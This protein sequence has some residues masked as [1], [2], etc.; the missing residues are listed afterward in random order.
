[1]I[2]A[3]YPQL[4][5]FNP[6][7]YRQVF[8]Y[9]HVAIMM[10]HGDTAKAKLSQLFAN[11]Y[12]EEW[13]NSIWRE[14]HTGHYHSEVVKDTGG[15][16]QHQ[17]GTPKPSDGY[18]TKNG[19]TLGQKTLKL[20]EYDINGILAEYTLKGQCENNGESERVMEET[21]GNR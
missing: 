20:L 1:M 16:I 6:G 8:S 10:A 3:R 5:V 19:F 14:V 18:E 21:S 11:E 9:G 2:K 7:S 15:T 17:F 12:P 4:L 13:S